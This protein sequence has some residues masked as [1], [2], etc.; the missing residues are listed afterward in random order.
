MRKHVGCT[1]DIVSGASPEPGRAADLLPATARRFML[2]IDQVGHFLWEMVLGDPESIGPLVAQTE[3]NDWFIPV[4]PP[5]LEEVEWPPRRTLTF[6]DFETLRVAW[7]LSK[8][9][10]APPA[11]TREWL[12]PTAVAEPTDRSRGDFS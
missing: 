12:G 10:G 1:A 6:G 3:D 11:T 5:A 2:A 9:Q 8:R 7:T 4:W